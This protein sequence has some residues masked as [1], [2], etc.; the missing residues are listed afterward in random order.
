MKTALERNIPVVNLQWL[1]DILC[2]VQIGISD[3][4]H[5]KYQNFNLSDPFSVSYEMVPHLMGMIL[6]NYSNVH[7]NNYLSIVI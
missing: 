3:P 5:I 7:H 2:G 1:S 6:I 4:M